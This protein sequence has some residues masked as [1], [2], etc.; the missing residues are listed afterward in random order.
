MNPTNTNIKIDFAIITGNDGKFNTNITVINSDN[1]VIHT[2]T[3]DMCMHIA[4]ICIYKGIIRII[5]KFT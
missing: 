3:G 2:N 4:G 5:M 1:G